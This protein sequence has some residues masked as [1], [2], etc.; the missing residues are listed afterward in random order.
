MAPMLAALDDGIPGYDGHWG[1]EM[2]KGREKAKENQP[3]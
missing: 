2:M 1:T 3:L